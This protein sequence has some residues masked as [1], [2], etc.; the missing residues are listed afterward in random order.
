METSPI[1]LSYLLIA[2]IIGVSSFTQAVVGV[3]VVLIAMPLVTLLIDVRLAVPLINL[4]ALTLNLYLIWHLR[5]ELRAGQ[6]I[7]ML[8]ASI[9]GIALGTWMLMVMPASALEFFLGVTLLGYG[10][11]SLLSHKGEV[12]QELGKAWTYVTGLAGGI[13]GGAIAVSGPPLILY[14]THQPWSK[15]RIKAT[16]I[17]FFTGSTLIIA[18]AQFANGLVNAAVWSYYLSSLPTLL[19]GMVLGLR[20]YH[21]VSEQR[22]RILLKW[23]VLLLGILLLGK[24]LPGWFG[25]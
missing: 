7:P 3:G 21:H 12:T 14:V 4:L 8:L 25:V 13:L 1:W 23:V 16:L 20:A 24:V 17:G 11:Y 10:I 9:P 18:I 19:L 6:L 5:A 15:D 22:Y 2:L